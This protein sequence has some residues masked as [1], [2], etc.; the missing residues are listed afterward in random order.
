MP[1]TDKPQ[2]SLVLRPDSFESVIG[3]ETAINT[4]KTK[5]DK[6]EIPR[7]ILIH[8]TYGCGKTTLAHIIAKY[9]QG[10][11]FE[12]SP[13]VHEV[14]GANYR[15]IEDMRALAEEAGSYPMVGTYHVIIMDECQQLTKDAQQ[16]LL[17][18]L[19]V[20]KSPTVWILCT[21][22]PEKINA[23]VRDRSFTL[24]VQGM[25][26]AERHILI[27][28]AAKA[29][30][31]TEP[32]TEFEAAVTAAG[33]VSPRKVIQAF[34]AYN[35]G[36][37][38]TL[39][40]AAM[41][42][43]RIPEVFDIAMG[44]VFGSWKAKYT[45]SWIKDKKTGQPVRY[46]SVADQLKTLDEKLKK[47][48]KQ[49]VLDGPAPSPADAPPP[50]VKVEDDDLSNAGKDQTAR[51]L[52]I[53]VSTL[54]KNKVIKGGEDALKAAQALFVLSQCLGAGNY[55]M[56]WQLTIGGLYRAHLTLTK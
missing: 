36:T 43:E 30:G 49:E 7:A 2:L 3:L 33:L 31:R 17:K 10:A 25:N 47:K 26:A 56:E 6:D 34:D 51:D 40:V 28:R 48:P 50:E 38:A 8:G 20:L 54:L 11:L 45:L 12:G 15:K 23:G 46:E 22:D 13:S 32:T 4:I 44:V 9:I 41:H 55:G 1:I 27:E 35:S 52:L 19:E 16:I 5:L 42:H 14:N 21:T 29:V 37:P 24:T 39:A 53:I 18:E